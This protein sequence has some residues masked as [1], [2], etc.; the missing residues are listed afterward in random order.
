MFGTLVFQQLFF[1]ATCI[2]CFHRYPS[3][4]IPGYE[5]FSHPSCE[6]KHFLEGFKR[7]LHS[8]N[9]RQVITHKKIEKYD[10]KNMFL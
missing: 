7:F 1:E 3:A 2:S 10:G 8:V 9:E 6:L 5:D 4:E